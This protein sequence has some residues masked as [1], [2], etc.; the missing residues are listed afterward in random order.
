MIWAD[1]RC[2]MTVPRLNSL[3][4]LRPA[5]IQIEVASSWVAVAVCLERKVNEVV[6]NFA[7]LA[8]HRYI[9][10]SV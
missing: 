2:A 4:I 6:V 9:L 3:W 5:E 1:G 10:V 7:I 8:R